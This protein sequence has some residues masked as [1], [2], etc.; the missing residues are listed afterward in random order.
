MLLCEERIFV[1]LVVSRLDETGS[2]D[3]RWRDTVD[4]I[5]KSKINET[6]SNYDVYVVDAITVPKVVQLVAPFVNDD[7]Q[8]NNKQNENDLDL[9]FCLFYQPN[10]VRRCTK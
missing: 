2:I 4:S 8:I 9:V 6:L 10:D 1:L 5:T 3:V 7:E